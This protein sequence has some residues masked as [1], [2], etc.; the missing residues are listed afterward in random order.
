MQ[1]ASSEYDDA[2][3]KQH[4]EYA[5]N[6]EERPCAKWIVRIVNF[7]S[8]RRALPPKRPLPAVKNKHI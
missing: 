1:Y 5:E 4:T 7:L 6:L 2:A 3:D 8:V